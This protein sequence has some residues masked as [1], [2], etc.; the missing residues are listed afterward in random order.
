MANME[1]INVKYWQDY[2]EKYPN[3]TGC[4]INND[5]DKAWFKNGLKHREDGPAIDCVI[6]NRWW[7]KNG[8]NHRED[9]PAI[10]FADGDKQWYLNDIY[11]SEQ[12]WLIAV[13]KFK[14]EKVLKKING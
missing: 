6:G 12:E 10:E 1:P 8:K 13:R 3:F 11:Y 7:Y 4:L 14:L 9:G 5:N 2:L